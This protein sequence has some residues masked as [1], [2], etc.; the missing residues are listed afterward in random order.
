[1]KIHRRDCI[2]F[3]ANSNDNLFS[4]RISI[5]ASIGVHGSGRQ[6]HVVGVDTGNGSRVQIKLN[7]DILKKFGMINDD[8]SFVTGAFTV[9]LTADDSALEGGTGAEM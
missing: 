1:M 3:S 5:H 6:R 7:H 4:P 2:Y 9:T 8:G